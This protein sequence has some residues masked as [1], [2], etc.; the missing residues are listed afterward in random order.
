MAQT[1][2]CDDVASTLVLA[3]LVPHEDA[4]AQQEQRGGD[5]ANEVLGVGEGSVRCGLF[6]GRSERSP[7][8]Q[9]IGGGDLSRTLRTV[10]TMM[11][12]AKSA[13]IVSLSMPRSGGTI[14]M[15]RDGGTTAK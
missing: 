15:A 4:K 10:R 3:A 13:A 6:E 14:D 12:A 7:G 5:V 9:R 8:E 1:H 11:P 2:P